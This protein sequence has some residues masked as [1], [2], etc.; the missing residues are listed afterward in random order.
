MLFFPPS[1]CKEQW[2]VAEISPGHTGYHG[3]NQGG[4]PLCN[5]LKGHRSLLAHKALARQW[6]VSSDFNELWIRP[7]NICQAGFLCH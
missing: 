3:G 2:H 5:V 6:K 1:D 4:F 7:Y